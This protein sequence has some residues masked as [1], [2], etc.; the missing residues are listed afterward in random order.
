[1]KV[2]NFLQDVLI[3]KTSAQSEN[4]KPSDSGKRGMKAFNDPQLR[5]RFEQSGTTL[6]G[7]SPA[8]FAQI[9]KSDLEKWARVIKSANISESQ[10]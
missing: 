6:V 1:M 9:I 8:E 10:Q 5:A 4:K 3:A 2:L 7:S